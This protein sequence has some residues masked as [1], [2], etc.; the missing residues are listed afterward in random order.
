MNTVLDSFTLQFQEKVAL[1]RRHGALKT[2]IGWY[3]DR[4]ERYSRGCKI[5]P[6][7]QRQIDR[8]QAKLDAAQ[9]ELSFIN[10]ELVSYADVKELPRDSYGFSVENSRLSNGMEFSR[11]ELNIE[12]SL[13][14][15]TFEL[16]DTLIITAGGSRR[17]NRGG[18]SSSWSRFKVTPVLNDEGEVTTFYGSTRLGRLA[19]QYD[20]FS[21]TVRNE[22]M[23]VLYTEEI[24]TQVI[25]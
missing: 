1:Q 10:D 14:D 21:M 2:A 8:I 5:R 20:N 12:D 3:E 13:Y 4:I 22:D 25:A 24:G 6:W 18:T 19:T 7:K 15:D 9:E 23:E 17:N 16:G 11:F